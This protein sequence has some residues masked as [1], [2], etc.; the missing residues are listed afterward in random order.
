MDRVRSIA[1]SGD[2]MTFT[3]SLDFLDSQD[4]FDI[5]FGD[6]PT[7]LTLIPRKKGQCA[8]ENTDYL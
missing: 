8:T 4:I 7:I 6:D 2:F 1:L 5:I 3:A